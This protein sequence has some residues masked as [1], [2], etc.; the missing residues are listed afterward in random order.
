M[1]APALTDV[2]R[3]ALQLAEA[4]GWQVEAEARDGSR[5]TL[6]RRIGR[7]RLILYLGPQPADDD[8]PPPPVR[9]PRRR[10]A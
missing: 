2:Q 8:P 1:S 7:P 9:H 3:W 10:A 5:V 4:E 6:A